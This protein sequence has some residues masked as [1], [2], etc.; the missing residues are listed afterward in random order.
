MNIIQA[1]LIMSGVAFWLILFMAI[2]MPVYDNYKR[3]FKEK[4]GNRYDRQRENG[5]CK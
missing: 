4:K 1:F 2:I 3:K 5:Y